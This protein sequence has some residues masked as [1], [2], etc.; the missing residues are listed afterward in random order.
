MP[1][2]ETALE[3][4]LCRILGDMVQ[5]GIVAKVADD[6]YC[7]GDS[8]D[9]TLSACSRVLHTLH[10][11]VMRLSAQKTVCCP[12]T[13]TVLGWI[14]NRGSIQAPPHR[15]STLEHC[16]P[17]ET[18]KGLRALIGAYTY[19]NRVISGCA[20]ALSPLEGLTA[21]RNSSDKLTWSDDSTAAFRAAQTH[22][23]NARSVVLPR[24]DDQIQ[25]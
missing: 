20:S 6:L 4:L 17:P 12:T 2:S 10:Q 24:S 9:A 1:G 21:G 23:S 16:C 15:L 18:V 22:L 5:E 3:E 19:L 8:V 11:N 7:G 14:W 13:T 25:I